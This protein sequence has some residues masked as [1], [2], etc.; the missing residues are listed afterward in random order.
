MQQN[1]A[2][3]RLD[4]QVKSVLASDMRK[5]LWQPDPPSP[6]DWPAQLLLAK[7]QAFQPTLPTSVR[8]DDQISTIL[9]QGGLGSCTANALAQAIRAG[10]IQRGAPPEKT[11]LAS[12]L[13]LYYMARA[14]DGAVQTDE[15]TYFRSL[16]DAAKRTGY[17]SE[18][19]WPYDDGPERFKLQPDAGA[20]RAAFDQIAGFTY[21]KLTTTGVQRSYDLRSLLAARYAVIFGTRVSERFRDY[22]PST[23]PLDPPG[24][25]EAMLGGHALLL[26][27]YGRG[28]FEGVNSWGLSWGRSGWFQIT[29]AYVENWRSVD[30]WILDNVTPFSEV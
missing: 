20:T 14:V 16:L 22:G 17:P 15:G 8:L 25:G 11:T 2:Q 30:F 9:D 5:F 13:Y 1:I 4:R 10:L 24:P 28:Y 26:T 27:G 23:P 18:R 12:R 6:K 29:D 19:F 21:H 3:V 7:A